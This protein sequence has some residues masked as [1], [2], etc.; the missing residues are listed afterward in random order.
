MEL[1]KLQKRFERSLDSADTELTSF[2]TGLTSSSLQTTEIHQLDGWL[3]DVWQIW[4]RFCRTAVFASCTGCTTTASGV[5]AGVHIN[6]DSIS[7][8]AVNQKNGTAPKKAGTNTILRS[9]P[10][11]GHI[12]KLLEVITALAPANSAS[13]L[14]G[15]GTVPQID[16]VRIIRNAS[17]HRNIQTYQKVVNLSAGYIAAPIRHP[18]EALL[19]DDPLTGRKLIQARMDDMRIASKN[20]C[21]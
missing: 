8:I 1:N 21:T 11:W 5:I 9:E 4:C 14:S 18:V 12:N 6:R 19:W 15:F 17:A 7:Y 3:S 10:T 16:D 20:V 13:L 2:L